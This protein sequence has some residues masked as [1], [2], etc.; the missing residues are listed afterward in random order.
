MTE[1][2]HNGAGREGL[3]GLNEALMQMQGSLTS[4]KDK[5]FGDIKRRIKKIRRDYV[6]ERKGSLFRGPS[7]KE[8]E[9]ARQLSDLLHKQE[10]MARQRS[11]IGWLKAGDRNTGFFHAQ[12]SAR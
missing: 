3:L 11:R 6:K 2:W 8:R 5:K 12:A 4:W 10:I 7:A 1:A 9:L